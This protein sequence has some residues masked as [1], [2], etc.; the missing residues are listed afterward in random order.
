MNRPPLTSPL[1][2]PVNS[3]PPQL[4][5]K[6]TTSLRKE[7][8]PSRGAKFSNSKC[9]RV[10]YRTAP[11]F[12]PP[13]AQHERWAEHLWTRICTTTRRHRQPYVPEVG[14]RDPKTRPRTFHRGM[15]YIYGDYWAPDYRGLTFKF[16]S[17]P[18][19]LQS[20]TR[21]NSILAAMFKKNNQPT[22]R[23]G[24]KNMDQITC[25]S[26]FIYVSVIPSCTFA[27]PPSL[28]SPVRQPLYLISFHLVDLLFHSPSI[29][30]I[31]KLKREKKENT[32]TQV[33]HHKRAS[34]NEEMFIL[35]SPPPPPRGANL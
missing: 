25:A 24:R 15:R 20:T 16:M 3:N 14:D 21:S 1:H 17:E 18:P 9:Q 30:A 27:V 10:P 34:K 22:R 33:I 7:Q 6:S 31:G 19:T 32:Q 28:P 8:K 26:I 29:A 2:S 12:Q 13:S 35:P 4:L 11:N 5:H 23:G